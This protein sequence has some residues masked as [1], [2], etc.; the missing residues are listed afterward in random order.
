MKFLKNI[1][2]IATVFLLGIFNTFAQVAP[3][4]PPPP[5]EEIPV[6]SIDMHIF[7]L[8]VL[9]S[10]FGIYSIYNFKLKQKTPI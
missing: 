3:P 9:A 4:P 10:L 5:G 7:V 2:F 1:F 8:V 6:V